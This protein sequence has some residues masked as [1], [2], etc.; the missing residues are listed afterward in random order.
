M[1]L[2]DTD[3]TFG[4]SEGVLPDVSN[5]EPAMQP[6]TATGNGTGYYVDNSWWSALNGTVSSALNY[7]IM[8][9]QQQIAQ[10]TGT[11]YTGPGNQVVATPQAIAQQQNSRLLLLG[12]IAVGVL[13]AVKGK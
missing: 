6:R 8:R 10:K 13:F 7:A 1:L 3:W 2:D 9:D 11:M 12:L 5:S 4:Y